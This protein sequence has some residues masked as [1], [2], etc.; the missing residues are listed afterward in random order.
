MPAVPTTTRS[1]SRML[2]SLRT[3]ACA[4]EPLMLKLKLPSCTV[5]GP[6]AAAFVSESESALNS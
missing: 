5:A 4:A 2:T 6:E 3:R 1:P